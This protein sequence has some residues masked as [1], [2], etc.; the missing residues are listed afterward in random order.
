MSKRQRRR[1]SKRR[2]IH[3]E[4]VK[5]RGVLDPRWPIALAAMAAPA[6]A[7]PAAQAAP[8]VHHLEK[9]RPSAS[10]GYRRSTATVPARTG[11][12]VRHSPASGRRARRCQRP[13]P[14]RR[15]RR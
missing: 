4:Q 13:R 10:T 6:V 14:P 12:V 2:I 7:A 11:W 8:Q 9:F 15:V 5:R 1:V 3:M